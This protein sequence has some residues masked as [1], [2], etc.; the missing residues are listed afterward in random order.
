MK[1]AKTRFVVNAI[2]RAI[3]GALIALVTLPLAGIAQTADPNDDLDALILPLNYLQVG[4]LNVSEDSPKFG[5]YN[6]LYRSGVYFLGDFDVRGG[7]AYGNGGGTMRWEVNGENLGTTSRSA[8]AT[9][10]D[11]GSWMLGIGFDQSRHYTTDGNYQT[12]YQGSPGDNLFVLS[13]GFGV[14]NT[15]TTTSGGVITSTNKGTQTLTPDQLAAFH[16][17][18][19]YTERQNTSFM[20]GYNFNP[21][22]GLKFDY[23]RLDQSGSKLIGAATD[24]YDLTG[25]G[26]FKY[27]GERIAILPNPTEYKNDTFNFAL[28]W[29]GAN[30]FATAAYYGSLFHD[31]YSG[32]TFSNPYVSG[33]TGNAP[34]PAPG[35]SPG[36]A[37]PLSTMSTPPNNQLH[38]FNFTGGYIFSP[39]TKLTGGFSYARGTQNASYAGTYTVVPNTVPDLPVGSLDGKVL[40]KHVDLKLTHQ[41][42]S[43]LNFAAGFKFNERDNET[44]SH[45]YTFLD[46]G[47]EEQT[48][49]NIPMSNKRYQ[50][51][52]GGDYRINSHQRLHLGYEYDH[53]KR[54]CNN[55]LANNAQGELSSTNAGYYTTASCVQVPKNEENRL[56][57]SYNL[58]AGETV[59]TYIRYTYGDRDAT[60]NPS[61]YNPMQGNDEGFENFGYLAFFDASRKEH[62]FKAGINWQATA[63]FAVDLNGRYTKDDYGS[64]LGVQK[65]ETA[66]ANLDASYSFSDVSMISAYFSWQRRTRN[67]F[68]ASGR[69]AVAPLNTL[70]SND[71]ADRDN[72]FGVNAAQ[73]DLLKGKFELKEDFTYSLSKSKYITTL[74]ANINPT[75]ANQGEAPNISSDLKQFRLSGTYHLNRSSD[76]SAGY[77]YQRLK[78]SDYFYNAFQYGFTPTSLLPTNQSAPNYTVN[79][80]FV[81]YRY[82]FR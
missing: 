5:E 29:V 3:R 56:V 21:E 13:P 7:D 17:D 39:A 20:A 67:L 81:A 68:T 4:A 12:P 45:T 73:K 42:T 11:Q 19:I 28:N 22:W 36:A 2:T 72:T 49:V 69:N 9:V 6:G 38:Q 10:T 8:A 66:S 41:A 61:F 74:E 51:D 77:L 70:W 24:F 35:T 33:G 31:D 64:T 60:V 78:A 59:D 58:K 15:T 50:F 16:T 62:L 65:G 46:L 63:K 25:S 79:T 32:V 75:L 34:A 52:V 26:G 48:V 76:I 23:K 54:W 55:A 47:G 82:N 57:A 43:A 30:A 37:F 71:L 18:N 80:V 44:P 27:G 53:I 14:I 40:M 1:T